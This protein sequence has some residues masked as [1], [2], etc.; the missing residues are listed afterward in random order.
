MP[1]AAEKR[2]GMMILAHHSKPIEDRFLADA[3]LLFRS[4]RWTREFAE[5]QIP[6][7]R[8]LH[9]L[10]GAVAA[11]FP[12]PAPTYAGHEATLYVTFRQSSAF[13]LSNARM[14][15]I[16]ALAAAPESWLAVNASFKELDHTRQFDVDWFIEKMQAFLPAFEPDF[17]YGD[18]DVMVAKHFGDDPTRVAWPLAYY[19]PPLVAQIGR[20]MLLQAPVW[21]A[22][23]DARG[24]I[25]LQAAENP[26]TM[27]RQGLKPLAAHLGLQGPA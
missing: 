24:G 1:G 2:R 6:K 21:E 20:E 23:E 25:W 14:A 26:F 12:H 8:A 4:P 5:T 7:Q 11:V 3:M 27:K 9:N 17:A 15:S 22:K 19:G 18:T 16:P 10:R 13:Q